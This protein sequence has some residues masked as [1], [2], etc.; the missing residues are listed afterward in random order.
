MVVA[1]IFPVF[2]LLGSDDWRVLIFMA[3][4][5][6]EMYWDGGIVN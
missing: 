1:S 4:F 5:G 6:S 3:V 2:C